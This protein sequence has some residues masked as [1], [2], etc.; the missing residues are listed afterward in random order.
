MLA[1]AVL[2]GVASTVATAQEKEE[3]Y[4]IDLP[5]GWSQETFVDGAKIRRTEYVYG[6][7]SQGLLKVKRIRAE[8]GQTLEDVVTRDVEGTLKFL[9]AYVPGRA[10]RFGG[11]ALQGSLVQFDFT[12]GGRQLLGRHYY[13]AG[14]DGTVWVLQFTGDRTVLGQLRNV[15]DQMARSFR[16]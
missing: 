13:L 9:P 5:S 2:V 8:R 16:E 6:D 11:G 14:S 4:A 1:I 7:R 15:T 12:R 3:G 10:E